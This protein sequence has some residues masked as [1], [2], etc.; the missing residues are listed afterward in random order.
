MRSVRDVAVLFAFACMLGTGVID[1]AAAADCPSGDE[2]MHCRA[3]QGDPVAMYVLGRRAYEDARTSGDFTAA[4]DWARRLVAAKE[5]N[6]ERLLTM[7]HLQLGWGA[8]RDYVQAYVWL[9]EGIAGGNESLRR[10]RDKLVEKMTAEQVA[11]AKERA[12]P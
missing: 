3:E 6:G 8:H 1:G 10:W 2:G 9:S 7:V 5:K 11:Q 4:L 12:G